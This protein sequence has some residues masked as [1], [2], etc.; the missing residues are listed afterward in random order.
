MSEAIPMPPPGFSQLS[1][2]EQCE[3]VEALWDYIVSRGSDVAIPEW[4][5]KV[6][7]ERMK[8]YG[9]TREGNTWDEFERELK[10]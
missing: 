1:V 5:D 4:H 9:S 10:N 7:S 8:R 3:Y 6:I 2:D